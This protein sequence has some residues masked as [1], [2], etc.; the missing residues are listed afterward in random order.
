ML[1]V[2]SFKTE[3]MIMYNKLLLKFGEK[4]PAEEWVRRLDNPSVPHCFWKNEQIENFILKCE[5]LGK[6]P[7]KDVSDG[8][9]NAIDEAIENSPSFDLSND[10]ILGL[11]RGEEPTASDYPSLLREI[12]DLEEYVQMVKD[13]ESSKRADYILVLEI[14]LSCIRKIRDP[15][16]ACVSKQNSNP[17]KETDTPDSLPKVKVKTKP[18]AFWPKPVI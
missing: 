13:D 15:Q 4:T 8:V 6:H 11:K 9:M 5:F 14:A 1:I 10:E 7:S 3:L 2:S 17:T 18:K 16:T 12:D